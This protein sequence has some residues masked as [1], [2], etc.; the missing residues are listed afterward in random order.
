[1]KNK[2]LDWRIWNKNDSVEERTYCR[3][4]GEL[5]EM[6]SAKQLRKILGNINKNESVLDVGCA[7]GHF[8]SIKSTCLVK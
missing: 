8:L 2:D 6:E 4:A 7:A 1:M 3:A 5:P